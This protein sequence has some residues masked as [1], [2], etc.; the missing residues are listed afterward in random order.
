MV[1]GL[2]E[3]LPRQPRWELLLGLAAL[4]VQARWRK[5]A[6]WLGW[7]RAGEVDERD[8][9][10]PD[11]PLCLQASEWVRT[12][13]PDF[14]LNHSLRTYGF[15][16]ALARRDGLS[17]DRE[18]FYL[19][20]LMHDLGLTEACQG[21]KAFEVEGADHAYRYLIGREVPEARA[22]AVHHA[23]ALHVRVGLAVKHSREGALLQAGAGL[24]VI[25]LRAEDL[26][27]SSRQ[28]MVQ[29]WPRLDCKKRL[30]ESLRAQARCKPH[31]N[32]AGHVDLGFLGRIRQA[33]FAE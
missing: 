11:T 22:R 30:A 18:L 25:G 20:S 21:P 1:G 8:L 15:G 2:I 27:P 13:S 10:I 5:L 6:H 24:D 7:R 14:L 26:T 17:Y 33:P 4:E 28:R 19:A 31:C 32:L 3:D 12:L 16:C 23:I 29:V 9:V